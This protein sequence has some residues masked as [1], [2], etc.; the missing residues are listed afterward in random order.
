MALIVK[1]FRSER[2]VDE[3]KDITLMFDGERLDPALRFGQTDV[4][5]MDHVDVYVR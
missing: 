1:A 2:H 5:D 3:A 4:E